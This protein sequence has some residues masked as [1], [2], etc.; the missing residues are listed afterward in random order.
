MKGGQAMGAK[1]C[2]IGQSIPAEPCCPFSGKPCRSDCALYIPT[3]CKCCL[4]AFTE[5]L[6]RDTTKGLRPITHQE[7]EPQYQES[8]ATQYRSLSL[9]ARE[10]EV[11]NLVREGLTSRQVGE[12]LGLSSRTVEFYRGSVLRKLGI[13]STIALLRMDIKEPGVI[14]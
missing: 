4:V 2:L 1:S 11:L 3:E 14:H 5:L 6:K 8:G 13:T 9:T 10:K 12:R 7:R